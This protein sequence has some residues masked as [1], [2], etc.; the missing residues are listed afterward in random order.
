MNFLQNIQNKPEYVRWRI[1]YATLFVC[2]L[3]VVSLW[4]WTI[5]GHVLPEKEIQ[6]EETISTPSP[7]KVLKDSTSVIFQDF[8]GGI[9]K[10][11]SDIGN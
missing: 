9:N 3:V 7:F 6:A 2:M 10:I 8:V 5:R 4:V 1:L 11:K